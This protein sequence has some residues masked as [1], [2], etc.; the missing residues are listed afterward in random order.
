MPTRSS[1]SL[2]SLLL[3]IAICA[4]SGILVL[5]VLAQ[6]NISRLLDANDKL[7][8]TGRITQQQADVDMNHDA[9]RA[10]VLA[11]LL[12]VKQGNPEGVA[13]ARK[14]LDEHA[15]DLEK[16]FNDNLER[17]PPEARK[18]ANDTK[19]TLQRYFE[20]ARRI[21]ANPDKDSA[22]ELERFQ[23]DFEALE[24]R[25][26]DLTKAIEAY[27][28]SESQANASAVSQAR[29][30]IWLGA[31][32]ALGILSLVAW[33][34]YQTSVPPLQR[35]AADTTRIARDGN[36]SI[37]LGEVGC[38]EVQQVANAFNQLI[39]RQ[40]AVVSQSHSTAG[41]I[42]KHMQELGALSGRVRTNAGAQSSLM[43]RAMAG[44]EESAESINVIAENAS[45]AASA[46]EQAGKISQIGA[47]DVTNSTR[48]FDS[49]AHTV[50]EI[51]AIIT[52]LAHEANEISGV[53]SAIRDIA[54]QTNL[55]ALNAAIEAAR[56]GEQ[57]RGFAVVA[58]EVR[59]L[60]ERTSNSTDQIF[61]RIEQI[62][63]ASEN[64]VRGVENGV[65]S[66]TAGIERASSSA[67]SVAEIPVAAANVVAGMHGIRD[68]LAAQRSTQNEVARIIEQVSRDV[69]EASHD[70]E[71][72]DR[73]IEQ[74]RSAMNALNETVHQFKV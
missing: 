24:I 42:Y 19:P 35:M 46:A 58:D 16:L 59:K 1:L 41:T 33:R 14:D 13:A 63:A 5:A 52:S 25:L 43:Q 7:L 2:R 18:L 6:I 9:V 50:K 40:R 48:E 30:V 53:A 73:L 44:F 17:L 62:R 51:A 74:T 66:V 11:V 28:A 36:L 61:S 22:A 64:A 12:F 69:H 26:G 47:Q 54:D 39:V 57:G 38:E 21:V 37:T 55:L 32:V 67:R 70:A 71:S 45:E 72:L 3:T 49:L 34:V 10:D 29:F 20:A 15:G 60:A 8:D 4:L 65:S 56:A 31:V 27:A 68:A 23:N